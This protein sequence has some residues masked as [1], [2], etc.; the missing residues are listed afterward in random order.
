MEKAHQIRLNPTPEQ[1]QYFARAAGV[2]RFTYNWALAEWKQQF[3]LHLA[4]KEGRACAYP[5]TDGVGTPTERKAPDANALKKQFNAIKR[6]QFPFVMEVTKC[7]AEQAFA[8]LRR[9]YRNFWKKRAYYPRFKSRKRSRQSFYVSNDKF[10]VGDHWVKLP[11]LGKVNMAENLRFKG[12]ILS[13]RISRTASWWYIS[14]TVEMPNDPPLSPDR[15]SV[16]IDVGITA[17]AMTSEQEEF[18]NQKYLKTAL[19]KLRHANKKLHRRVKG[20]KNREKAR[21]KV[22]RLHATISNLR[23][24]VLHKL[25][26][27]VADKYAFVGV[28]TLNVRGMMKNRTLSRAFA[29]AALRRLI[30][31]LEKKV[32]RRG[33]L[34]MKVG[35][36]FPSTQRC[37]CCGWR[38]EK[39]TLADRVFVCQ[40]REHCVYAGVHIN[41]DLNAAHNIVKEALRLF[42]EEQ[43]ARQSGSGYDGL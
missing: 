32:E 35:R 10:K 2:A 9:A 40:N 18:E 36:F 5:P 4:I 29:D 34:V 26:T 37:H 12:K 41:R 24:D 43:K 14:I 27:Y 39:I 33:G 19:C 7:A 22:A 16:G 31:F 42:A 17:L 3:A 1:A 11:H 8:D 21:R 6:G 20:S 15:P 25:T 38:W 23:D 13:A 30:T 28:E